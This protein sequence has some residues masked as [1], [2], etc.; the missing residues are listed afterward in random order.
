M[1]FT[2]FHFGPGLLVKGIAPRRFSWTTFVATQVVIDCETLYHM[3]HR[4]YPV[5]RGMHTFI[6]ATLAGLVTAGVIIGIRWLATGLI[7]RMKGWA[8]SVRSEYSIRGIVAGGVIGGVSHPL[9]DGMMHP[10]VRPFAPWTDA[11]PLLRSVDLMAL[12]TGCI[13]AGIIGMVL[14][15]MWLSRDLTNR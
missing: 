7:R 5:H 13:V 12:H 9:L 14:T 6:G 1:P 3:V 11:N 15:G 2:P 10:D 4:Q 8:P